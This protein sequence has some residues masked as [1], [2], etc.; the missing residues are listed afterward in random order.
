MRFRYYKLG[1]IIDYEVR[2]WAP[3]ISSLYIYKQE[4]VKV[5]LLNPKSEQ[6]LICGCSK[7]NECLKKRK[8]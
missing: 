6:H 1:V 8:Y 2:S 4:D 3:T 5:N 7:N